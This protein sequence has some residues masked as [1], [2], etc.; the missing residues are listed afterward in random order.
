M[1]YPS[2]E[3]DALVRL[4]MPWEMDGDQEP[5]SWINRLEE[6]WTLLVY[7]LPFILY[8]PDTESNASSL[9]IRLRSADLLANLTI[10]RRADSESDRTL[11]RTQEPGNQSLIATRSASASHVVLWRDSPLVAWNRLKSSAVNGKANQA[12]A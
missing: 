5:T 4:P 3:H 7:E 8:N 1:I 10:L 12:S 6:C 2:A 11:A 9:A